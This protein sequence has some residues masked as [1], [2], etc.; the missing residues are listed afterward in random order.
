MLAKKLKAAAIFLLIFPAGAGA[1]PLSLSQVL[2]KVHEH[3]TQKSQDLTLQQAE[4]LRTKSYLRFSP[5]L[6]SKAEKSSTT[7]LSELGNTTWSLSGSVNLFAS[8]YDWNNANLYRAL[9]NETRYSTEDVLLKNELSA[10]QTFFECLY[11]KKAEKAALEAHQTWLQIVAIAEQRFKKGVASR[12]DYLKLKVEADV[13]QVRFLSEKRKKENCYAQL[14]YWVGEF[15]DLEE[16]E[17]T[18]SQIPLAPPV[19]D[20]PRQLAS[21]QA[22]NRVRARSKAL[23]SSNFPRLDL[24]WTKSYYQGTDA[25][26][27]A[28]LLSANW[29]LYDSGQ[30][31]MD[32]QSSLVEVSKVEEQSKNIQRELQKEV[33]Q[34]S[35]NLNESLK[36]YK[37][38]EEN[39][40][41]IRSTFKTSLNRYRAG[42]TTANDVALDQTRVISATFSFNEAWL[43]KYVNFFNYNYSIGRRISKSIGD[44]K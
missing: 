11:S 26:A 10:S 38:L 7:T 19:K 44:K 6:S 34:Q 40:K 17:L 21:E 43:Q 16:A 8:F 2:E 9:F 27:D 12:D 29:S 15:T 13:A 39:L 32:I 31:L 5:S 23:I 33:E 35:N 25:T 4:L 24:I 42:I 1:V 3:P 36:S 18:I 37:L 30:N 14:K 22:V 28:F 41:D 20:H